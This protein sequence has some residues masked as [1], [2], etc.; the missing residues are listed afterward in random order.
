MPHDR[1]KFTFWTENILSSR[2]RRRWRIA[3]DA[4]RRAIDSIAGI[5]FAS[6]L[7]RQM[8]MRA[9][10]IRDCHASRIVDLRKDQQRRDKN[11]ERQDHFSYTA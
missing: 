6:H 10:S 2:A 9:F 5:C 8:A 4:L 11:R 3:G 1:P 7:R